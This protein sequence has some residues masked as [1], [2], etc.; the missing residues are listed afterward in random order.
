MNFIHS[1]AS[2]THCE[3]HMDD[4]ARKCVATHLTPSDRPNI[5]DNLSANSIQAL[6]V[7]SSFYFVQFMKI[8]QNR[9]KMG[10]KYQNSTKRAV[11]CA[12][13]TKGGI[14]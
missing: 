8:D 2:V 11:F 12:I 10:K 3:R 13:S 4:S 7:S 1:Y 6:L 5:T 9:V 14:C